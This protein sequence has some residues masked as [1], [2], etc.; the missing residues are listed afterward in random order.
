MKILCHRR[1][2]WLLLAL[3]MGGCFL[4]AWVDGVL[5]PG[6]GAKAAIK[7][8]AFG[9]L[10]CL[11]YYRGRGE[12]LRQ[13]FHRDRAAEK[14]LLAGVVLYAL[15]LG[16]Y[17]LLSPWLDLSGVAAAL[18]RDVGVE[19]GNFLWVALYISFVNSLLEEFFFRG[20]GFL[21]LGK[22]LGRPLACGLSAGAFALYHVA[23]MLG[24]MPV[25]QLA[26][27]IL[28]L[29]GAGLFFN[30]LNARSGTLW[31]SWL[32]HLWANLAINTI[33]FQLL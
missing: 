9:L 24:W 17:H 6:Y 3:L 29:L 7:L 13:L 4:L 18:E 15:L 2:Q 23:M 26:L 22:Y 5:R 16:G 25:G 27:M 20:L 31:T 28:G 10:P 30:V 8:L 33:G 1:P 19:A 21:T 14:A 11:L 12:E 32:L